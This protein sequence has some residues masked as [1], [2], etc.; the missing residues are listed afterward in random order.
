MSMLEV[1]VRIV[2]QVASQVDEDLAID[3]ERLEVSA[4]ILGDQLL[5]GKRLPDRSQPLLHASP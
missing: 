4:G 3:P 2:L 5:V 1:Q